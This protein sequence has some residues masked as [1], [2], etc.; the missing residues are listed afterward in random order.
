MSQFLTK[1]Q[2]SKENLSPASPVHYLVGISE[3]M[4]KSEL[5]KEKGIRTIEDFAKLKKNQLE[6]LHDYTDHPLQNPQQAQ[7]NAEQ[8]IHY[9]N[10]EVM[11]KST[12]KSQ[13]SKSSLSSSLSSSPQPQ[14]QPQQSLLQDESNPLN[15]LT[16]DRKT[17]SPTRMI[18]DKA[19]NKVRKKLWADFDSVS[20]A[21]AIDSS[22]PKETLEESEFPSIDETS[23]N[24][25]GNDED[26]FGNSLKEL[27]QRKEVVS[28]KKKK[29][30]KKVRII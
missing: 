17:F 1:K 3:E 9:F 20:D 15:F 16:D 7:N 25:N 11:R 12:H 21:P 13:P 4:A 2:Y 8:F 10:D 27:R 23:T 19:K 29:R 6:E 5:W 28:T 30:R 14:P 24:C 26:V 18:P 22:S